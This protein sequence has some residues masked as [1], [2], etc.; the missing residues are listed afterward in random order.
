MDR[1][2]K[3][4]LDRMGDRRV[5]FPL[6]TRDGQPWSEVWSRH[7]SLVKFEEDRTAVIYG[8]DAKSGLRVS[9]HVE[10]EKLPEGVTSPIPH[11]PAPS[12]YAFGLDSGCVYG[13]Q[14][15]ALILEA[16]ATGDIKHTIN[17]VDC[18]KATKTEPK[19]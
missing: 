19:N 5:L 11:T 18:E 4:G 3:L 13:Y 6:E 16:D 15:S 17:S 2:T 8:H 10:S 14:L 7:Q 12:R 1:L 9:P